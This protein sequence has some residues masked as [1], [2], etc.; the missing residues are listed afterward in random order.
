MRRIA[1]VAMAAV[2][3]AGWAVP[4]Q[5]GPGGKVTKNWS[6]PEGKTKALKSVKVYGSYTREGASVSARGTLR[7]FG[8]NGWSPGVQFRAWQDG[9]WT[10]SE[11]YFR[12]RPSGKPMDAV[13]KMNYGLFWATSAKHFQ[14][15]EVALKATST[16][17]GRKYGA[18]RKL[19]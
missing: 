6:T 8:K 9:K 4:A 10:L 14:V 19:F 17:K 1:A 15:R 2:L 13:F 5:A 7:D 3:V 16:T 18:W 11:V 12:V